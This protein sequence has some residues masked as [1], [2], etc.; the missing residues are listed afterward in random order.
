MAM[1]DVKARPKSS[2]K[3]KDHK[4]FSRKDIPF[5]L[6]ASPWI[7]GMLV[8]FIY[9]A[10]MSAYYSLTDYNIV[11]K[12]V[13]VG[14]KNYIIL[15][16]K[17]P[18]F[19][20][21]ILNTLYMVAFSL[22]LQ[23]IMQLVL[24]MMLNWDLKGIGIFRAIYYVPVLVPP[25]SISLL[26]T[27]VYDEHYGILN[28]IL[29]LFGL[30]AQQWLTSVQ[31]SKPSIII[32][33]LWTAGSGML[34]YL[35]SLKNVPTSLYESASIDGA[36][37]WTKMWKITLPII[38]P[39]IFFQLIMGVISTFQLFTESYV[40]TKGGPNYSSYFMMYYLYQTAFKHG[41]MGRASAMAWILF[42]IILIFTVIILKT[43]NK[44]V[45]YEEEAK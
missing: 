19:I 15:F 4:L 13:F 10:I 37:A 42:I 29:K 43:S 2:R 16:T 11:S 20:K 1:V 12:P 41:N 26:F 38:S 30:P 33:G 36:S 27:M 35:S 22:P 25:V 24:A 28:A 32:M 21:A 3:K 40:L 34:F 44:W 9:P 14:F 5:Y 18:I 7:I 8:F 6:F 23:L 39:T 31:L 45:Y 17:D